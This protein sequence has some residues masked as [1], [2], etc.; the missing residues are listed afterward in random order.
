MAKTLRIDGEKLR[1]L[2]LDR[3][4]D[5]R[6]VAESAGLNTWTIQKIEN[7][8]WPSGSKPSTIR[9]LAEALGVD[10]HDLLETPINE[11]AGHTRDARAGAVPPRAESKGAPDSPRR[12]PSETGS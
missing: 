5:T 11:D 8:T 2:R 10:P 12:T 1:A 7:G 3:F 9:K 4:L 6:E